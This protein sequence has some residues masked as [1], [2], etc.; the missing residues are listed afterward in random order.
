VEE[1]EMNADTINA[2][3]ANGGYVQIT[4]YTRSTVYSK[5]HAGYFTQGKDGNL[6]VKRG[7]SKDCL[8]VGGGSGMLVGIRFLKEK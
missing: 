2:Y 3:L 5:K 7:K 8:T 1:K 4:T 6:Y